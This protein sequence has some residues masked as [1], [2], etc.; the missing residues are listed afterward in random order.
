MAH[1]ELEFSCRHRVP[2]KKHFSPVSRS[3]GETMLSG[4]A[5]ARVSMNPP[6]ATIGM[7][8]LLA[9]TGFVVITSQWGHPT[10]GVATGGF[11]VILLGILVF[12]VGCIWLLVKLLSLIARPQ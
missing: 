4:P 2:S 3:K 7:G 6:L 1:S 10:S 11:F 5:T 9:V 12:V 8:A